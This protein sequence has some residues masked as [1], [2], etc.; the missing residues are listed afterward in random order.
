MARPPSSPSRR[1]EPLAARGPLAQR[2]RAQG[3]VHRCAVD[4]SVQAAKVCLHCPVVRATGPSPTSLDPRIPHC[5]R[6]RNTR[7]PHA[8]VLQRSERPCERRS[9]PFHVSFAD[10]RG[11]GQPM[12]GGPRLR[13]PPREAC[14]T[15]PDGSRFDLG[16][17]PSRTHSEKL[18]ADARTNRGALL[19]LSNWCPSA[20]FALYFGDNRS[21]GDLWALATRVSAGTGEALDEALPK[22]GLH[23]VR[24][25]GGDPQERRP[26]PGGQGERSAGRRPSHRDPAGR[27]STPRRPRAK[28]GRQDPFLFQA[29]AHALGE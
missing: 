23:P 29:P 21:N 13:A 22:A 25:V 28:P 5:R 26:G 20:T 4:G 17:R 8:T 12:R 24:V 14:P 11:L 19:H 7:C 10:G 9:G 3:S 1:A 15:E 6:T 18:R 16:A 2:I 27:E